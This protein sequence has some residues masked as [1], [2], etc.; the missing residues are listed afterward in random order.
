MRFLSR[1][2]ARRGVAALEFTMVAIPILFTTIAIIEVSIESWQLHSM[3]YAVD[4]T[5]R[6][7]TAHGRTCTRNNNT[8]TITVANVISVLTSQAPM[9]NTANLN[10]TLSGKTQSVTCN[11]ASTCISTAT[12]FP[13]TADNGVGSKVTVAATYQMTNPIPMMWFGSSSS[14]ISSHTMGAT[15]TQPIVY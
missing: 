10:V 1:N 14:T 7:V 8:C 13:A 11:P 5:C 15:S 9:L 6:Y 2:S 3:T 12:Q 4:V